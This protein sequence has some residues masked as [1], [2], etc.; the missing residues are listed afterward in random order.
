[1]TVI[2]NINNSFHTKYLTLCKKKNFLPNHDIIKSKFK[3]EIVADRLKMHEWHMITKALERD[4]SL[5][6]INII[7]RK[8]VQCVR[9][10]IDSEKRCRALIAKGDP[11]LS[12][13]YMFC[14]LVRAISNCVIQSTEIT[15]LALEGLPLTV[16]YIQSIANV[17][18]I[19][20]STYSIITTI[21]F[22]LGHF[23]K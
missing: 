3:L 2:K 18:L 19:I 17:A 16:V 12:T 7:S 23:T 11:L 13:K 22:L 1:M 20:G 6:S 9:E 10:Q 5:Q 14:P 4:N 8:A 15:C 21:F